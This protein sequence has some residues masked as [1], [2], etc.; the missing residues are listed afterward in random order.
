MVDSLWF[1][2]DFEISSG[3]AELGSYKNFQGADTTRFYCKRCWTSLLADHEF[4]E[5]RVIL[6]Q[7]LSFKEYV[8]SVGLE[9]FPPRCRHFT[10]DLNQEQRNSL[11]AFLG[12][13][14]HIYESIGDNFAEVID[15]IKRAGGKDQMNIHKIAELSDQPFVSENE[16]QRMTEAQPTLIQQAK[17]KQLKT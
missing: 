3:I 1:P 12:D 9:C 7:V 8:G 17:G 4:Y 11:P 16:C 14:K 5:Q 13:E 6:T 10:K 2:N 15:D